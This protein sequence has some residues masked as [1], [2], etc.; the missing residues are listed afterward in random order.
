MDRTEVTCTDTGSIVGADILD[1]S[2]RHLKVALDGATIALELYK[3]TPNTRVYI[4]H[5][6]GMEFTS[7]GS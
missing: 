1:K 5:M 3:D 7:E 2:D 4:G 6:F